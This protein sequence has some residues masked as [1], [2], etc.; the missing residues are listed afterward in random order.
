MSGLSY[1]ALMK[2]LVIMAIRP[3]ELLFLLDG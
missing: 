1:T 2:P 3:E